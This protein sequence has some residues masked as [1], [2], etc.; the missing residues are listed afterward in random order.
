[1]YTN[2]NVHNM[3]SEMT[4]TKKENTLHFYDTYNIRIIWTI[5]F[6]IMSSSI[7]V[8]STSSQGTILLVKPGAHGL[9]PHEPGFLKLLWFTRRYAC[10]C[11]SVCVSAHE[12]INNQWHD[13]V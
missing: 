13:M 12:A 3:Y 11:L 6:V 1:M 4:T 5:Y 10:V 8:L 2:S 7:I 9:R